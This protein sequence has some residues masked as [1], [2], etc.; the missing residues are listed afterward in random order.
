[1]NFTMLL[2][3]LTAAWVADV[4]GEVEAMGQ[5]THMM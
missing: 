1:M 5:P 3:R 2:H 4:L